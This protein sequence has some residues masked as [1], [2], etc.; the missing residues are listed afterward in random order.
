MVMS[1]KV[2]SITVALFLLCGCVM[3]LGTQPHASALVTDDV[4]NRDNTMHRWGVTRNQVDERRAFLEDLGRRGFANKEMQAIG[5]LYMI[6]SELNAGDVDAVLTCVLEHDGHK[7]W[8]SA[9]EWFIQWYEQAAPER[10]G[11]EFKNAAVIIQAVDAR[12]RALLVQILADERLSSNGRLLLAQTGLQ[13]DKVMPVEPFQI[14]SVEFDRLVN[15]LI[16][17][18]AKLTSHIIRSVL[19]DWPDQGRFVFAQV[20]S[21]LIESGRLDKLDPSMS[22]A[23]EMWKR[24]IK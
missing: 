11:P 22:E 5:V 19:V 23:M 4:T 9:R 8:Q 14:G 15:L 16:S 7:T 3:M 13:W 17:G 10:V 18:D 12:T 1:I 21:K 24:S 2:L 6:T 20:Y